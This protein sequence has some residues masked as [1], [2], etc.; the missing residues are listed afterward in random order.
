MKKN[1]LDYVTACEGQ[2]IGRPAAADTLSIL[3]MWVTVTG[4]YLIAPVAI[5]EAVVHMASCSLTVVYDL[6]YTNDSLDL[7]H[8][9]QTKLHPASLKRNKPIAFIQNSPS[10]SHC[11]NKRIRSMLR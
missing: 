9:K 7:A 4:N 2:A 10:R 6:F 3:V 11:K 8:P 1:L 5:I